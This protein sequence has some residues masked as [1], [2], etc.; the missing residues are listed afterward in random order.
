MKIC[1]SGGWK[2]L[3][4]WS[5]SVF[6]I[7]VLSNLSSADVTCEETHE[8]SEG[9]SFQFNGYEV[10]I[11]YSD[12]TGVCEAGLSIIRPDSSSYS[13]TVIE[14]SLTQLDDTDYYFDIYSDFFNNPVL[15]LDIVI[16]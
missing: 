7:C 13:D 6:L 8:I 15:L 14:G 12:C 4:N 2:Y 5:M 16:G 10:F 1:K 9:Y 11:S 3:F